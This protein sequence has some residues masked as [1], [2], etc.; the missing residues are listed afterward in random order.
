MIETVVV[1]ILLDLC[2][3]CLDR[4]RIQKLWL[5]RAGSLFCAFCP[6]CDPVR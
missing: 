5:L 4:G 3:C 1:R 2:S 6:E